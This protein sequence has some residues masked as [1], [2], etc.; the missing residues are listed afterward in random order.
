MGVVKAFPITLHARILTDIQSE[1]GQAAETAEEKNCQK[2]STLEACLYLVQ[3]EEKNSLQSARNFWVL[4][5]VTKIVMKKFRAFEL[6]SHDSI[7]LMIRG[8]TS[9][10]KC[11]SLK[12][13]QYHRK[14]IDL[15]SNKQKSVLSSIIASPVLQSGLQPF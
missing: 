9:D 3:N 4:S 14:G 6:I 2:S 7:D 1:T 15:S 12:T 5:Q 11:I 10:Y 13:R 8:V